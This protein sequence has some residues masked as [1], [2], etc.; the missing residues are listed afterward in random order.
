MSEEKKDVPQ[1]SMLDQLKQQHAQFV[2]QREFTLSNLNQIVGAIH[3]CEMLIKKFSDEN[4]VNIILDYTINNQDD[5][6]VINVS[7]NDLTKQ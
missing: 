7:T 2:A 3:A 6:L 1:L 5:N 4:I